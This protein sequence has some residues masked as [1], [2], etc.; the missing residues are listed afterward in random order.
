MRIIL[1]LGCFIFSG[2]AFGQS[3]INNLLK[4]SD[5]LNTKRKN[6][7]YISEL[8][9]GATAMIGL[10]ELWYKDYPRSSF[11]TLNDLDEWQGMDKVG[12]VF[13]SYQLSRLGYETMSWTGAN[14]KQR[15]LNSAL[16][17]LTFL[18]AVEVMDGFSAEWGFSWSDI[19]A[20]ALGTGLFF[21]QQMLWNEQRFALKFS[22]HQ[23][24][25]ADMR[26]EKLGENLIQEVFK[27]Y[28]GQTYWLSA[29]L[30]SF[31]KMNKIPSW[32]NLAFGYGAEGMLA[33]ISNSEYIQNTDNQRYRQYYLSL[34]IDLTRIKTNSN[35]LKTLFS[36]LNI[37]KIPL[38]TIEFSTQKGPVFHLLFF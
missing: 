13:S 24:K 36:A 8:A 31:I 26:P 35:T 19:T 6:A 9:I 29:N 5:S 10:N 23:T 17:G 33:G 1:F 16:V 34:D 32:L 7:L 3:G 2:I 12:H 22:F 30:K 25:F 37:V 20:N 38:P 28:N 18:T 14:E 21:G 15:Y 27:D 4:P 11:H